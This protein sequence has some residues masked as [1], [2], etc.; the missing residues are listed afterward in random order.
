[1][2]VSLNFNRA[3]RVAATMADLHMRTWSN[4]LPRQPHADAAPFKTAKNEKARQS[5]GTSPELHALAE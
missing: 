1:M 4:K 5:A 2:C 3:C